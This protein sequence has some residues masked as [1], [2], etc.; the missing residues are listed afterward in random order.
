MP[1]RWVRIQKLA[2]GL[3]DKFEIESPPVPIHR[4]ARGQGALIVQVP[5]QDCNIDGF[6]YQEDARVVI[7]VNRD[8]ASVR[9]RFTI[10][11]ELGHLLLHKPEAVHVDRGFRV[12]LRSPASREGV[13]RAEMEANRFAAEIL[14]PINFLRKDLEHHEF[15]L[16]ADEDLRSLARRYGVSTQALAIRLNGLGY[17]IESIGG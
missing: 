16:A 2:K 9:K 5:G 14:M 3:L 4:L 6:L 7:G 11:H 13:E 12:R 8:Q 15:D 1:D 17:S 10:A